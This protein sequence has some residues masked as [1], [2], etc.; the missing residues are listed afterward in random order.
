[1]DDIFTQK[2]NL[3]EKNIRKSFHNEPSF[4]PGE[5]TLELI[6][7]F[8]RNFRAEKKANILIQGFILN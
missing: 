4:L 6:K 8:A 3:S 1:M 2:L 5:Q 7:N